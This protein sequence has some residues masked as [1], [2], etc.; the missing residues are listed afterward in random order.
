MVI[1]TTELV[2][3]TLTHI[4]ITT[5]VLVPVGGCVPLWTVVMVTV[6]VNSL[7]L[8]REVEIVSRRG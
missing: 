5:T 2:P 1:A 4:H 7:V 8:C 6:A 3:L